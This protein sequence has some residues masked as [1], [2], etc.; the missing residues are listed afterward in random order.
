MRGGACQDA[1]VR[2]LASTVANEGSV[3]AR[4]LTPVGAYFA[5]PSMAST[6]SQLTRLSNQV[7]RYLGRALR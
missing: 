1:G 7:S 5:L 6:Y 4:G 2:P 3:E